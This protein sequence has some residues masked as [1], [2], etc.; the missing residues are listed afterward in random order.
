MGNKRETKLIIL[1]VLLIATCFGVYF[2]PAS[3]TTGKKQTLKNTLAEIKGYNIVDTV[4]LEANIN[5]FLELDDYIYTSYTHAGEKITLFIGYYYTTEKISAAHSPLACFPSQGWRIN[6]PETYQLTVG[7][8]KINYAEATATLQDK[9][10]LVLYWYQA[11]RTTN[12][13]IYRNK[14]NTI[15]NRLT[16]NGEEHA[17]V[18]V[19]IPF[20]PSN[21]EN[22]KETGLN[23]I[24]AFYPDF[25]NFVTE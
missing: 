5:D 13:Q 23:F 21:K 11:G 6:Q 20:S 2:T 7:E 24:K 16:G 10:E 12:P 25:I 4:S 3:K 9:S 22:A 19:T 17:F 14:I 8:H 15:L 1:A 18:R